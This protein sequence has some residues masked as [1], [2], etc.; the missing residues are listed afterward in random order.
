MPCPTIFANFQGK[1]NTPQTELS[2]FSSDAIISA[3]NRSSAKFRTLA[4]MGKAFSLQ[5]LIWSDIK[6]DETE[7]NRKKC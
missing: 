4:K 5:T 7:S 2:K 3:K 1:G 6:C